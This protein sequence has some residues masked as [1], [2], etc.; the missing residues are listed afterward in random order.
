M[1]DN[2]YC[3]TGDVSQLPVKWLYATHLFLFMTHLYKTNASVSTGT[4]ALYH[5][6]PMW[7]F[8]LTPLSLSFHQFLFAIELPL[9]TK[10][11][12]DV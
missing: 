6:L 1:A 11:F 9:L 4:N 7:V 8:I 10:Q 2:L 12:N 3:I 5:H